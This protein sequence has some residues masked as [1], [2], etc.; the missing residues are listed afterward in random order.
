MNINEF[1]DL[2]TQIKKQDFN[3]SYKMINR[4]LLFLSIF[5]NVAS[6]F[7]AFFF[8]SKIITNAVSES[9]QTIVMIISVILLGG[10]ELLKRDIFDKF[11]MEYLR[12]KNLLKKEVLNLVLFSLLVISFSFY[13]SLNGAKEFSSKSALIE[14]Q[15]K[16][17]ITQFKDSL[18]TVYNV[19]I[20][21]IEKEIKG[22]KSKIEVKDKEQTDLE[23]SSPLT[24]QQRQ[25]IRDLKKEKDDLR[26]EVTKS[27]GKENDVK[28]ELADKITTHEANLIKDADNK[29]SENSNNSFMFIIIS[30]LIEI[31]ILVGVYFNKYYKWRSYSDMKQKLDRDPNY[32]KWSQFS[33][34]LEILYLNETKVNDR[35]P[36]NKAISDMCRTNGFILLNRD[37]QEFTKLLTSLKI[38]RV[39]GSS[40]YF[41]K[42]KDSAI[43]TIKSYFNIY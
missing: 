12:F 33:A 43:E 28:K 21:D 42:D 14:E 18:T 15:A 16:S 7:L 1:K 25:R 27:E 11:S 29:K 6:I 31:I 8:I 39:S 9:N 34:I 30:T 38:L 4:V 10:L 24:Y 35:V 13:C 23:A 20:D 2:E 26:T 36:S 17:N 40:R 3:K 32:Q 37:V 19:K 5:G 22:Y 41:A